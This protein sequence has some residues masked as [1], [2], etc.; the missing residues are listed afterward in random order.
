MANDTKNFKVSAFACKCG[1]CENK[2]EQKIIDIAQKI[3]ERA[4]CPIHINSGY[5]CPAHNS[6]PKVGGA[7]NSKH[8]L[9]KA[10]DLS[11]SIGAINLFVLICDMKAKGELPD[12]DYTILYIKKNFVH[13]DCGGKRSKFF[14]IR[15]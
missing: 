11:C 1:K 8:I 10:A 5:R 9:G 3:R 4:G 15:P 14:E 2:I 6:D 12:L 7:K 13:V